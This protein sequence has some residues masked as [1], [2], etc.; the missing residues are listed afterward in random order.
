[1]IAFAAV[2]AVA[3]AAPPR[4]YHD[5]AV[6]VKETP[7]DN[8]GLD[9]YQFGY[10]LSNGQAHQES[11]QL[12]NAGHENEALV[13]RGSFTYVDPAT[14]VRYTVNYV[15]DENG[16]HPE[17]AHLPA[18]TFNMKTIIALCAL[19]AVAIAAPPHDQTVVVKET[20]L[21][22]IGID[23]YQYGYE[24]SNGQAHQESAQ[25]QNAG[26][27]NEALVVRG[28]FSYV[29]PETNVRYTVNYVADENGF[30]PEGAHLPSI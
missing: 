15:A 9:G 12:Q 16:F 20:P 17:G 18:S 14:N 25:L 23:G 28:S 6:V 11:A 19:V 22:N 21:D 5:Q 7:L 24:L 3:L 30:H 29:D 10:E 4:D 1:I 26:H 27:E 13:V 2:V 8:I